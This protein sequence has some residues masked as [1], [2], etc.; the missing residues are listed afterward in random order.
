MTEIIGNPFY[1]CYN[2]ESIK[3]EA[4]NTVY[5]AAGNCLIETATKTLISGCYT[6]V[7]PDDGSVEIIGSVAFFN[8]PGLTKVVIPEG[9]IRI[10][11]SAFLENDEL[12][13]VSLPSTIKTLFVPFGD[14]PVLTEFKFAGTVKQWTTM[15][16]NWGDWIRDTSLTQVTCSDGVVELKFDSRGDLVN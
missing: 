12:V 6:S 5:H 1:E 7:I 9:V 15:S 10:M 3:V 8:K 14:N 16:E 11:N 13:S 2:L 4:G